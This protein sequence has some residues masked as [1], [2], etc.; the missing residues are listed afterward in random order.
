MDED[1]RDAIKTHRRVAS[2][3]RR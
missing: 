2:V 1:T 3:A